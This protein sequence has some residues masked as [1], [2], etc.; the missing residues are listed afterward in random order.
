[1]TVNPT[2]DRAE[3][4]KRLR[5]A[6]GNLFDP[7]DSAA[8]INDHVFVGTMEALQYDDGAR[9]VMLTILERECG[10]K[11]ASAKRLEQWM[12][13]NPCAEAA[14]R[15]ARMIAKLAR[16]NAAD[17][18]LAIEAAIRAMAAAEGI[19]H[20]VVATG[21]IGVTHNVVDFIPVAKAAAAAGVQ[22][23]VMAEE[24]DF[25]MGAV[26]GRAREQDDRAMM[27]AM[28]TMTDM[29][30]GQFYRVIGQAE[31]FYDRVLKSASAVYRLG[32]ELPPD[33]AAGASVS[34]EVEV[35]RRGA[36]VHASHHAAAPLPPPPPPSTDEQMR[37]AIEKGTPAYAV[38]VQLDYDVRRDDPAQT[39]LHVVITVPAT[40]AGPLS[41]VF[42]IVD[43]A[44]RL[45]SGKRALSRRADG[46]AYELDLLVPVDPG[47]YRLRFAVSDANGAVGATEAKVIVR[48]G[49]P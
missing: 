14:D 46:S 12:A 8:A 3:L 17:Q 21:G 6:Q 5:R 13:D 18:L 11:N 41:G 24:P 39:A 30:G 33:I 38:P 1:V 45:K 32:V 42:G 9:G 29:A 43:D 15:S 26:G 23:S 10:I 44:G 19:K 22:L 37:R 48:G 16:R 49:T 4:M 7:R 47:T 35:P 25:D 27:S 36:T 34:V 20:L 28:Q 40:V 31:R 2:Q